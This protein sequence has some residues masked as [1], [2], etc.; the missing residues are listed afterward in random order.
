MRTATNVGLNEHLVNY[1]KRTR[2]TLDAG[3][4]PLDIH[5][6]ASHIGVDK[7]E[8]PEACCNLQF[9]CWL[10]LG[11]ILCPLGVSY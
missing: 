6:T 1:S 4:S 11:G 10:N 2:I 9:P 8:T 5:F 7:Q 3:L